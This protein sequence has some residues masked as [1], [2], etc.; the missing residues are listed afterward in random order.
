MEFLYSPT[1][2][3]DTHM[4]KSWDFILRAMG[5][6]EWS[7]TRRWGYLTH[8][9]NTDPYCLGGQWVGESHNGR[10][11][12][13]RQTYRKKMIKMRLK[14][15][16]RED[17]LLRRTVGSLCQMPL[18]GY[19]RSRE[20][21]IGFSNTEITNDLLKSSVVKAHSSTVHKSPERKHLHVSQLMK[22]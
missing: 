5:S 2:K 19:I 9:G 7:P 8:T 12:R 13:T 3:T 18:S 14:H 15:K 21:S 11:R 4:L 6:H 1:S 20:V 22:E 10:K 17:S 16:S